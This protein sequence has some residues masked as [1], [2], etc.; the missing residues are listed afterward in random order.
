MSGCLGR[1]C[2]FY[3]GCCW[4]A[5]WSGGG[6]VAICGWSEGGLGV[7]WGRSGGGLVVVVVMVVVVGGLKMLI[8][9]WLF[10]VV[11]GVA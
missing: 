2:A 10:V 6:L 3:A 7:V 5:E 9:H 4:C 1:F 11:W 8:F